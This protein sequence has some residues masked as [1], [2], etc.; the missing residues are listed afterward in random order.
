MTSNRVILSRIRDVIETHGLT[1]D[2]LVGLLELEPLEL[3]DLLP[4]RFLEHEHKFL[5]WMEDDDE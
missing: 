5:A 4:K 1:A 3:L 2:E